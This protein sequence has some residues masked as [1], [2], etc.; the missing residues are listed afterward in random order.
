M[1]Q[2]RAREL[3]EIAALLPAEEHTSEMLEALA[4]AQ[5]D[6]ALGAW[7]ARQKVF[8]DQIADALA[9]I[10]PPEGLRARLVRT[11]EREQRAR[12]GFAPQRWLAIAAALA[13]LAAAAA[14][15]LNRKVPDWK[16]E[17]LAAIV[18]VDAGKLPLDKWSGDISVLRKW[19]A[20][21]KSPTA[22]ALPQGLSALAALGCKLV[23]LEGRPAS[24]ICF[25]LPGS[26]EEAHL[27]VLQ[28]DGAKPS[29]PVFESRDGWQMVTWNEQ[30][31]KLMLASRAPESALRKMFA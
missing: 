6:P 20:S 25:A 21:E 14:L 29:P 1:N 27:A 2:D 26:K 13:L 28:A 12:R 3:L 16:G 9:G 5:R 19:L 30:G 4:L 31:R 23:Q 8:D 24:I 7:L 22:S 15:F 11:M 18:Q 10:E 17:T